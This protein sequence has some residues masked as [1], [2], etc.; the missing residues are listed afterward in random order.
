MPNLDTKAIKE[1]L[2]QHKAPVNPQQRVKDNLINWFLSE[3]PSAD[4][5][6]IVAGTLKQSQRNPSYWEATVQTTL[7]FP[8][9]LKVHNSRV[10]FYVDSRFNIIQKKVNFKTV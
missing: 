6:N 3:Q 4:E 1:R 2:A 10:F 5:A 9:G 8:C 7:F